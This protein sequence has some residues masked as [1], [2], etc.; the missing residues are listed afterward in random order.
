MTGDNNSA[1]PSDVASAR[2]ILGATH[3]A[4]LSG[5]GKGLLASLSDIAP[6]LARFATEFAYGDI[7]SRPGLNSSERQLLTITALTV[8]GDTAKQ[9]EF[10][11]R[12]AIRVG[13][14]PDAIVETVL[15][16]VGFAGF[17]RVINAM[18]VVRKVFDQEGLLPIKPRG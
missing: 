6:D 7:Y 12:G 1:Q 13:T 11:V 16:A 17:P 4:E 2:Y 3:I 15:H 14:R 8:L 9:L 5:N 10:H 18:T